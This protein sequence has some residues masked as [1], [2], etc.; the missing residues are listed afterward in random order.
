MKKSYVFPDVEIIKNRI[1]MFIQGK[2]KN[3]GRKPKER[4]S[5]FDYCYNYFY[6]F[7][8]NNKIKEIASDNNIQN[9]CLQL[10]FYLASWGMFRNSFL[11]ERSI[12]YYKK[13]I[14]SIAYADPK[15]WAIDVNAYNELNIKVIL[16]FKNKIIKAFDDVDK[17]SETLIS[18]IM[19][20]VFGNTPA[21]D[22]YFKK[23]IHVSGLNKC[24][25]RTVKRFY[26]NNSTLIDSYKIKTFDYYSGQE[27]E[28]FYSKA[29]IIDMY[30][31]S[32][33]KET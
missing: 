12:A 23:S 18:K 8:K 10:G 24:A 5:S 2:D 1:D 32:D 27:T 13:L 31:F 9:S 19:L 14:E 20:G 6:S 25:L 11:L 33:G 16:D 26:D 7:Y 28:N 21:F 22:Q 3:K 15:L 29:K 30:G 4:Y 17:P